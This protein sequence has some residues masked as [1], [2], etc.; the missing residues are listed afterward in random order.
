LLLLPLSVQ[1]E[2]RDSCRLRKE[3]RALEGRAGSRAHGYGRMYCIICMHIHTYIYEGGRKREGQ[4]P[5]AGIF[6]PGGK[7]NWEFHA[8]VG[9][10]RTG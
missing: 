3:T 4:E 1:F 2:I 7:R 9:H 6:S 8:S 5:L 10:S